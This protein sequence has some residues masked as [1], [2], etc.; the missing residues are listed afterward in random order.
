MFAWLVAILNRLVGRDERLLFRYWDGVR[1]RSIDPVLAH[2]LIWND[3]DCELLKDA[4]I[5]R[6]PRKHDG[7]DFY[8]RSEVHAAED[9]IRTLTRNVF[10]L[11]AWSE[12]T[13][14]LTLDETDSLLHEFIAF[15]DDFKKKRNASRT[16]S[17]PT[18]STEPPSSS[19]TAGSLD[20]QSFPAGVDAD[21]CSSA[22]ESTAAAPTG[23]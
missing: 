22:T 18:D 6:N 4:A 14:G 7:S 2:R 10:G 21:Y 3:Q 17:A 23:P 15:C 13:P 19:G 8:P 1:R 12:K 16:P 20:S 11:S 5:A 9:R